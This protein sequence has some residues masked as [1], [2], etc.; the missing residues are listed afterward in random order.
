M[1]ARGTSDRGV[2]GGVCLLRDNVSVRDGVC[3]ELPKLSPSSIS[4]PYSGMPIRHLLK[5]RYLHRIHATGRNA[6]RS[7]ILPPVQAVHGDD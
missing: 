4:T 7:H 3:P 1:A 5:R 6:V 2:A